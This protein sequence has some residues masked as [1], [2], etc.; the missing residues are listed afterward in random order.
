MNQ[1]PYLPSFPSPKR[2]HG[3]KIRVNDFIYGP[4]DVLNRR[5][6]PRLPIDEGCHSRTDPFRAI[7]NISILLN[8]PELTVRKIHARIH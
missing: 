5:Q 2:A 6:R 7:S 8:P 4:V 3:T 1:D